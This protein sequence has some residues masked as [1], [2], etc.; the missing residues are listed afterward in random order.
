MTTVEN[1]VTLGA[2][3]LKRWKHDVHILLEANPNY[4]AEAP[5]VKN[6]MLRMLIQL[7]RKK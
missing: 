5:Q 7:I 1:L 6:V 3:R 4:F 2:Y